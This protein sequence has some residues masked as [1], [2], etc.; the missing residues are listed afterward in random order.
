[1]GWRKTVHW[2]DGRQPRPRYRGLGRPAGTYLSLPS[3][4][5]VVVLM[6]RY[7]P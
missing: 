5:T 2:S 1:M 7:L 4:T 3:F 6:V